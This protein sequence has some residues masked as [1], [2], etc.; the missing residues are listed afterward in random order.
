MEDRAL[1][2]LA[3]PPLLYAFPHGTP[4]IDNPMLM[5][6]SVLLLLVLMLSSIVSVAQKASLEARR[7]RLHEVI[8]Q[9]W[10]YELKTVP[11]NATQIGDTR[12][13][14]QV[15]DISPEFY[16]SDLEQ[17]QKFLA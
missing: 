16:A 13:N 7:A 4:L 3:A 6:K 11:E 15:S 2:L 14:D 1:S 17:R 9:V 8:D 10:E 5:K 12:Y